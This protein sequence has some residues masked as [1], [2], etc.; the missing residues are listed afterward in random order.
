VDYATLER[1]PKT[2]ARWYGRAAR[3]GALPEVEAV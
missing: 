3:T 2:S 1:T